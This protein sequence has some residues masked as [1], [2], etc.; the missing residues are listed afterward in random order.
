[1]LAELQLGWQINRY[2]YAGRM[3]MSRLM[4]ILK[5]LPVLSLVCGASVL[6]WCATLLWQHDIFVR[7]FHLMT[8]VPFHIHGTTLR[9]V[10]YETVLLTGELWRHVTPAFLH[11]TVLHLA[12][13]LAVVC[14]LGRRA[15]AVLG[16]LRFGGLILTVATTS[17]LAQFLFEPTPLFGGLSGVNYGLVGFIAIRRF[18]DAD[19]RRWQASPALLTFLVISMVLLSAGVGEA[20]VFK[21]ANGAHWSGFIVGLA[22]SWLMPSRRPNR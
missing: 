22:I 3:E 7:A 16:P 20:V 6:G 4:G 8:F 19:E 13:N 21:V 14:E 9:F 18:L 17:N 2:G 1:M 15:E 5:R 11:F 10:P 12:L